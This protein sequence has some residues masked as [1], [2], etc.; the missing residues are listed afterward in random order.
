VLAVSLALALPAKK[1]Y[2]HWRS[3]SRRPRLTMEGSGGLSVPSPRG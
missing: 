1:L 2:G 3:S